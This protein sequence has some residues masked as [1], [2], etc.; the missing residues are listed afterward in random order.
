MILS[1]LLALQVM[2]FPQEKDWEGISDYPEYPTLIKQFKRSNYPNCSL[3]K[4][5]DSKVKYVDKQHKLLKKMLIMDPT[6]RITS[7]QAMSNEYFKME[8]LP[9]QDVFGNLPIPYPKREFLSKEEEEKTDKAMEAMG[10]TL[11][12]SKSSQGSQA[13]DSD[14]SVKPPAKKGKIE[15]K[16]HDELLKDLTWGLEGLPLNRGTRKP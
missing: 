3:V 4:Y 12:Q 6:K 2:G 11:S 16:Q 8:P 7:E 14:S 15:E 9:T 1:L 13:G 10:R 5:M